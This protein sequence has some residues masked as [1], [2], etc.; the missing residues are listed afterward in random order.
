MLSLLYGRIIALR[1]A[2]F[3][4]GLLKTRRL[5]CGVVS[6]GNITIGGTGK[7]PMTMYAAQA[8]KNLGYRVVVISRGYRGKAENTGGIVS[9]GQSILMAPDEAGDEPFMMAEKLQGTPVVV[10][11]DRYAAGRLAIA[12]FRPDLVILDDA[13]QHL[14]LHRNLDIV[15]LDSRR[16]V[17]NGHL[18]PRGPLREPVD[19][20]AR[21]DAVVLTHWDSAYP[22]GP[23]S[24]RDAQVPADRFISGKPT[25]VSRH[26]SQ[27]CGLIPG[28]VAPNQAGGPPDIEVASR[29]IEE[30]RSIA[31]SGIGMNSDF[32]SALQHMGCRLKSFIGFADHHPYS[33]EDLAEIDEKAK[34]VRAEVIITTE[35]D[36][37]RIPDT[38]A[39]SVDLVIMSLHFSIGAAVNGGDDFDVFFAEQLMTICGGQKG[40][41]R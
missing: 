38:R 35:K 11:K 32:E 19:S 14:P 41:R 1:N 20:L 4:K 9:D 40:G 21:A 10:G 8:A 31:F 33:A 3:R 25:F 36:A 27:V 24:G 12:S 7:T 39:L 6:V 29:R 23:Q 28:N 26:R 22:G 13:F 2:A 15:L 16:P 17:G 34:A 30:S 5:P 18:L 37:V